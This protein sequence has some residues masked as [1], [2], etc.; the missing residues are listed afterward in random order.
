MFFRRNVSWVEVGLYN[1]D[2][3]IWNWLGHW[4]YKIIPSGQKPV[5]KSVQSQQ[6]NV[7]TMLTFC[8]NVASLSDFEQVFIHWVVSIRHINWSRYHPG[9]AQDRRLKDR[10]L[11]RR[12]PSSVLQNKYHHF[13]FSQSFTSERAHSKL[14]S[15]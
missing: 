6:N 15:N 4:S 10:R 1:V 13:S 8:F 11:F 5:E 9:V 2:V 14:E 12:E 3:T 7:R